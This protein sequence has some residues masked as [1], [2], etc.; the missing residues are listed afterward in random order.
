MDVFREVEELFFGFDE[1]VFV[2]ALEESTRM[3]VLFLK[4][5]GVGNHQAAHEIGNG[6]FG[7]VLVD[8]K[9]KVIG[10]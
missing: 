7:V 4:V 6:G 5:H 9:V 8:K 1:D 2:A 10:H 3:L